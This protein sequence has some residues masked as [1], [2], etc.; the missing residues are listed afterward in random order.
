[1]SKKLIYRIRLVCIILIPVLFY[2]DCGW[3]SILPLILSV[4]IPIMY[5]T[6]D[7]YRLRSKIKK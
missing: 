4:G 6:Y 3:Y 2:F 7:I 1:M 5:Y